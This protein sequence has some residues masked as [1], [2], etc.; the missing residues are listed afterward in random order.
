MIPLDTSAVIF[1]E[2]ERAAQSAD[3]AAEPQEKLCGEN[4]CDI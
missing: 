2:K 3:L 4:P 1:E